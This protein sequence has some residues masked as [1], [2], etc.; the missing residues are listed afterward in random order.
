M[1]FFMPNCFLDFI[2]RL[3]YLIGAESVTV[4]SGDTAFLL[5]PLLVNDYNDF[6]KISVEWVKNGLKNSSLC[7]YFIHSNRTDP[8]NCKPRFNVNTE[9]LG[10]IITG[11]KSSDAGLYT[12]WMTKIIPPPSE[13][14][15]SSVW[16]QVNGDYTFLLVFIYS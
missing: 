15:N 1:H 2:N 13:F 8:P 10:L 4:S 7:K 5:C 16:L 9:P 3:F 14:K 6:D 12:C 11:V